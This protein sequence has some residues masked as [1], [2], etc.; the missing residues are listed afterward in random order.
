MIV[1]KPKKQAL[2]AIGVFIFISLGLGGYNLMLILKGSN[3]FFNYIMVIVFI[4]LAAIFI[5]RQFWNYKIISVGKDKIQAWYPFR[6]RTFRAPIK[7]ILEWEETI[8]QTKTGIFKQLEVRLYNR[9]IKLSIQENT[10]YQELVN[11]FKKKLPK[12]KK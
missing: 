4:P 6:F 11:Y 5:L 7:E 8:I 3:W 1:S 9:T 10:H 12:L 2:F